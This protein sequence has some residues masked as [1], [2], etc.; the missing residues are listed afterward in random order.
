MTLIECYAAM[1][2]IWWQLADNPKLNKYDILEA[3]KYSH[4]CPACTYAMA[5]VL[6]VEYCRICPMKSIW[7]KT[8][9]VISSPYSKWIDS[10][11]YDRQFF[12]AI[13][14]TEAD[15]L[16]KKLIKYNVNRRLQK[17][18][19]YAESVKRFEKEV[20]DEIEREYRF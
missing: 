14:A 5:G 9:I 6:N 11:G 20:S 4:N 19:N 18:A 2:R 8:C 16:L 1:S 15:L 7:T 12:A 10:E 3:N 17:D 13:I